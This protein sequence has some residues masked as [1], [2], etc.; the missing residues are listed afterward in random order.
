MKRL[1]G[2]EI[3]PYFERRVVSDPDRSRRVLPHVV[4]AVNEPE[5]TQVQA[6]GKVRYWRYV[7]ALGHHIR[8][9]TT[10][11]GALFNAHEDS[12]YTRRKRR[13]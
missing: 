3:A 13:S 2:F 12:E 7:P 9:I 10:A 1:E 8:V 5:E 11:D 6:D 4:D